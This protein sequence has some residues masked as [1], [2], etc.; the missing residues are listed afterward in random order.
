M[1]PNKGQF[2]VRYYSIAGNA[3]L[4]RTLVIYDTKGVLVYNKNYTI[5]K[6]HDKMEV[7]FAAFCKG[8]YIINLLDVTGK[9][10]AID[11]VVVQ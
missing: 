4:P 5:G 10:I 2:Q 9:R 3:P 8:L 1:N 7:N 11:K 6:P